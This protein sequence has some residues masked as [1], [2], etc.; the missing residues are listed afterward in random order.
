M[1]HVVVTLAVLAASAAHG[2]DVRIVPL[3]DSITQGNDTYNSWRRQFWF[4]VAGSN[5]ESYTFDVDMVGSQ[6]VQFGG[7]PPPD[8]DFDKDNEGHWG[9]S[10]LDVIESDN[11]PVWLGG[12]TPDVAL[13]HLGTN[14]SDTGETKRDQMGTLVSQLR[15]DNPN[16]IVFIAIPGSDW[17][18][19]G[20][21]GQ[22]LPQFGVDTTTAQS[23]VFIVDML[24]GWIYHPD[25]PDTDT[26]DWVHPNLQGEE[27]IATWWYDALR[28]EALF[29]VNVRAEPS[30]A[31]V[32]V[33]G[34]ASAGMRTVTGL[35][36]RPIVLEAP[37]AQEVGGAAYAF[38]SWSDGGARVREYLPTGDVTLTATYVLVDSVLTVTASPAAGGTVTP[39]G[40][41]AYSVGAVVSVSAAPASGYLFLCWS[42]DLDSLDADETVTMDTSLAITAVFG[43]PADDADADGISNEDELARGLHPGDADSDGDGMADGWEDANLLDPGDPADATLD[44]DLDAASNVEEFVRGTDP[45]VYDEPPVSAGEG[46]LSCVAGGASPPSIILAVLLAAALRRV[47]G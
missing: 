35:L 31:S 30:G 27:K 1:R 36:N 40:S 8:D 9:W 15:A 11:L 4:K 18:S 10:I 37:A 22:L 3:G 2:A 5:P 47:R 45:H 14:G 44:P 23:P 42:G 38:D 6:D 19:V 39:S 20:E 26:Q 17:G 43:L 12:Y 41:G 13:V 33:D 46:G 7:G 29:I 24:T 21:L 28:Q 25:D 32:T 16:V 34:M